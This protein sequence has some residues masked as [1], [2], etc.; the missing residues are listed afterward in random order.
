[1]HIKHSGLEPGLT[2]RKIVVPE[3]E[4]P[5]IKSLFKHLAL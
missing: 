2:V 4:K 5:P 3:P 1:M